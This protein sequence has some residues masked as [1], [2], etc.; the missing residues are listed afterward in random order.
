MTTFVIPCV[1]AFAASAGFSILYEIRGKKIIIASLCG[2]LAWAA[3]LLTFY[4]CKMEI[5]SYFVAG[6]V[7]ALYSE[8]AACIF[9]NPVTLFL[10]PGII[11]TVPGL[12]IY[13]TMQACLYG[14]TANFLEYGIKTLKIGGAIV[15]GLILVSSLWRMARAIINRISRKPD[16]V[17]E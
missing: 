9:K 13:H 14:D 17:E 6:A 8:M 11:P 3:Y 12:T 5:L 2:F 16:I 4:I 7:V 10:T 15:L 1:A